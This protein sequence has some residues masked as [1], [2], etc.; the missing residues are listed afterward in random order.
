MKDAT[1]AQKTDFLA[2]AHFIRALAMW[3]LAQT[4]CQPYSPETLSTSGLPLRKDND[5]QEDVTRASLKDTYDFILND[6]KAALTT[7]RRMSA[8]DGSSANLPWRP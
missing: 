1:E 6:L 5:Y 8:T 2:Q 7:T 4:Y 3:S